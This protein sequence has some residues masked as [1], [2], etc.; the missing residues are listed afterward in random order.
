METAALAVEMLTASSLGSRGLPKPPSRRQ[1]SRIAQLLLN[2]PGPAHSSGDVAIYS[3][4]PPKVCC[5]QSAPDARFESD[6][7]HG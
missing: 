1:L 3:R 4:R 2:R 5:R 7:P 6:S